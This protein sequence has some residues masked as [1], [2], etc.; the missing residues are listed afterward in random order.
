MLDVLTDDWS[1]L[2]QRYRLTA[3][4]GY[5]R[6]QTHGSDVAALPRSTFPEPQVEEVMPTRSGSSDKSRVDKSS[7]ASKRGF[8]AMDPQEQRAIA[9]KGGEAVSRNRAHMSEIGRKGAEV[10]NSD[11]RAAG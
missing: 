2:E 7:G 10:R 3:I 6:S 1:A 5:A 9:H 4:D 11:R 8:A